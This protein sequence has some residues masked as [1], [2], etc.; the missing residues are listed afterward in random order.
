MI[1]DTLLGHRAERF[2]AAARMLLAGSAWLAVTLDPATPASNATLT[3]SLLGL[4]FAYSVGVWGFRWRAGVIPGRYAVALHVIDLCVYG[5]LVALTEGHA[6]PFFAFFTFALLAA[7]LRWSV[8]GTIWTAAVVIGI[9]LAVG[10]FGSRVLARPDF[11]LDRFIIRG[12]YLVVV[13]LL[14]ADLVRYQQRLRT[15]LDQ[16]SRW[17]PPS[18][19]DLP[20]LA[21]GALESIVPVLRARRLAIVWE[22]RDGPSPKC[23]QWSE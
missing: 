21:A 3:Y 9:Y 22:Q 8:K 13:A 15:E 14:I 16:L 1:S 7:A 19:D 12:V 11:E 18:L 4:Y 17:S 6:S 20:T 10:F 23:M 2:V 5:V